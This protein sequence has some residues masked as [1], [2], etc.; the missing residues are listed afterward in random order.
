MIYLAWRNLTHNK[1][2]LLVS[3]AGV[4]LAFA[5][6]L[7]LDAIMVGMERQLAAY[8]DNSAA[9]VWVS[10]KGVRNLHMVFSSFPRS[11]VQRVA[12]VP[13]VATVT[14]ILYVTEEVT[15]G[16]DRRWAYV[17]GLPEKAAAGRPWRVVAGS[18][19]PGAG[20]VILDRSQ[21][22]ASG[23]GLGQ[24]VRIFGRK[25][26]V[27]GLSEG[28]LNIINSV[29]FIRLEDF[30]RIRR[31]QEVVSFVLVQVRPGQ[32]AEEVARRIEATVPGV[33]A[34]SRGSIAGEER[35]I[36]RDMGADAVNIMN[37][38]G[39]LIGLAVMALS[40]YTA[41]LSRRK[42]YGVLKALGAKSGYLYRVVLA[43]AFYSVG[44]GF[45]LAVLFT[46]LLTV[47]VPIFSP[48]LAL[49]L[50][51][52]SLLKVGLASLVI[53]GIAAA[54]PIRQVAGLDPTRVFK[55]GL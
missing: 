21:A 33:S 46:L 18:A 19:L 4:A 40:V 6:I 37:L 17:I 16:R 34:Q 1:V 52:A 38:I 35:R 22:T 47:V 51:G 27:A 32:S 29:A 25:F 48:N 41:T 26:K 5:L 44:L 50:S 12:A 36:T 49:E 14:P 15:M 20:E 8:I 53:A 24:G 30:A 23:V 39:L 31:S 7:V 42:E 9:E 43:Q 45:A 54:L 11:V 28:T 13:G 55:G 3:S 10:Q 2:R